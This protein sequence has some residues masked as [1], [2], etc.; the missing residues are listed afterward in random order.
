ME[1]LCV[2]VFGEGGVVIKLY[3]LDFSRL[4]ILMGA[5]FNI[6]TGEAPP[7]VRVGHT[8]THLCAH[9]HAKK[10]SSPLTTPCTTLQCV[11]SEVWDRS[12][13]TAEIQVRNLEVG[14]VPFRD[15]SVFFFFSRSPSKLC[16][17]KPACLCFLLTA[18]VADRSILKHDPETWRCS[19]NLCTEAFTLP[20]RFFWDIW[21]LDIFIV[22]NV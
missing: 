21:N 22:E 15:A 5:H 19:L 18:C 10:K 7:Y 17:H 14:L 2:D 3:V 20:L 11:I 13:F 4:S 6:Q 8:H 9:T 16:S 1:S 12:N